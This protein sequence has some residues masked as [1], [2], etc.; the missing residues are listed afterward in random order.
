ME[1]E[2]MTIDQAE[3]AIVAAFR[4]WAAI[5]EPSTVKPERKDAPCF[6]AW[7][8][9]KRSELLAFECASNKASVITSWL[10]KHGC[11]RR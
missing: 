2:P 6:W 5:N 11:I 10:H 1:G 9:V 4:E 7:L 8:S 3:P